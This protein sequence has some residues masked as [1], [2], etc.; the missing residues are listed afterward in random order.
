V[1]LDCSAIPKDLIES[2]LF[3]HEKGSFT[4]AIGQHRGSFEQAQGGTIFLDE[5]GELDLALQPKLLRVLEQRELKRV[6][7]DRTIKF[8]ARVLAATNR[9]LRQMVNAGTF[10]EDLYFRLSV[11][12]VEL[13]PLRER[14]DD[15]PALVHAFVRDLSERLG[16]S[17]QLSAD[18]MAAL[19]AHSFPGNV[20]ELRNV[21]ERAASLCEAPLIERRD[22]S[23]GKERDGAPIAHKSGSGRPDGDALVPPQLTPGLDFKEAKQRVVDAFELT[24]LRDLLARH[25]GNIT[26][27]AQEAG[28]TRYHLREL[29]KRHALTD[30][31][32]AK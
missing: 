24:Y 7:G 22:L 18:A 14:P 31:S 16:K 19:V 11:I 20:R 28:L 30:A 13:P 32:A 3:G 10:R 1:V 23:F 12:H 25:D 27:S 17:I 2:T 15:I 6:G 4:G 21:V 9:D 8:D 29:L 5:I 26:R